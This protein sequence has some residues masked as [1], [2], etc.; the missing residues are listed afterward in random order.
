V[1]NAPRSIFT[2][3]A[4]LSSVKAGDSPALFS[5]VDAVALTALPAS[6]RAVTGLVAVAGRLYGTTTGS[7]GHLFSFDPAERAVRDLHGLKGGAGFSFGLVRVGDALFAGTQ[8]DPT[9]IG[10]TPEPEAVGRLLRFTLTGAEVGVEDHGVA[11][12]GEGI[13]TLAYSPRSEEVVGLTFPAGHFLAHGVASGT[14][15]DLGAIAGHRRFEDDEPCQ[16]AR[17]IAVG[18]DGALYTSGKDGVIHRYDPE[19]G[20]L[21]PLGASIPSLPGRESWASLECAAT[22]ADGVIY[23]GTSDGYLFRFE[24]RA[25][26]VVNLGKPIR[27][28]GFDGIVISPTGLVYAIAGERGGMPREVRYDPRGGGF[29]LGGIPKVDSASNMEGFGAV[30]A[31]PNGLVWAGELD[32]IAR[33][34]SYR[35]E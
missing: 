4:L 32:R 35:I 27:Q 18:A 24:P 13:Y 25:G 26:L 33:L 9:G 17:A 2:A 1:N 15:R 5:P 7:A 11:I 19:S 10:R 16:V 34:V 3:L 22:A 12:A 21:A 8:R 28:G 14:T 30:V 31:G 23:G 20:S 29:V 6:E